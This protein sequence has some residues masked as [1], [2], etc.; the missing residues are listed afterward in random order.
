[1]K[2]IY[3]LKRRE[4][5]TRYPTCKFLGQNKILQDAT[6]ENCK[7]ENCQI[8]AKVDLKDLIISNAII[9][10]KKQKN[11]KISKNN[12]LSRKYYDFLLNFDKN[13]FD[14]VKVAVICANTHICQC[15][16]RLFES[17]HAD[18]KVY[19]SNLPFESGKNGQFLRMRADIGFC[20]DE[21]GERLWVINQNG[22][23]L[24]GD[25]ILYLL[26]WWLDGQNKLSGE[27]VGTNL[28]NLGIENK[29]RALKLSL[30]RV[31]EE[32][33]AKTTCEKSFVL[34]VTQG[35]KV[36]VKWNG[37][38]HGVMFAM[39]AMASI[40]L[41][42]KNIWFRVK[43]NKYIQVFKVVCNVGQ[44]DMRTLKT[45]VDFYTIK[46]KN[47]GRVQIWNCGQ[48]LNIL[49]ECVDKTMAAVL[50]LD[51]K[52]KMIKILKK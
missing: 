46:L 7:V 17:L 5:A 37:E 42:N 25:E 34:G 14:S 26:A 27:V 10:P 2:N 6:L 23:I 45:F 39:R 38:V 50:A 33:F 19:E 9:L 13:L 48:D 32:N 51:I 49:V 16:K 44:I 28:T 21:K 1:M 8:E 24:N 47:Q 31:V 29:L 11:K 36:A 12:F 43:E 35:G 52:K 4:L 41:E 18:V 22:Q 30:R 3:L 15:V 40:Y 20:V